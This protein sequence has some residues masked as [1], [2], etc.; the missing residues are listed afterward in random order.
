M[1]DALIAD[2]DHH[3]RGILLQDLLAQLL[4]AMQ[5]VTIRSF[6]RNDGAEQIDGAFRHGGGRYI[7]ECRWRDK[8][9]DIR[10]L[11]GLLGQVQRSGAQTM[12]L[13]LSVNGWSDNVVPMLKQNT[14]K[15]IVLMDG[16]DL[17]TVLTGQM[18]FEELLEAKLD[19]LNVF[20]EPFFS[21]AKVSSR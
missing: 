19:R 4:D 16:F 12:G 13:F 1:F 15:N 3:A 5:I 2:P 21:A 10:Q 8:L 17:R 6:T 14:S 18:E 11:D 7:V 20:G 9:A